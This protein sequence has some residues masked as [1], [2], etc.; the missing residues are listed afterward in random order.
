MT[1]VEHRENAFLEKV[2]NRSVSGLLLDPRVAFRHAPVLLP[3][4]W[5]G[6]EWRLG[7]WL[8]VSNCLASSV[9]TEEIGGVDYIN[10]R[11]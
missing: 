9:S 10:M 8:G 11:G 4:F 2:F 7:R 5:G 3:Q 6:Y 1:S